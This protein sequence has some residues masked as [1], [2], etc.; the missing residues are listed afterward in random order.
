MAGSKIP[1]IFR[2]AKHNRFN[3]EPRYYDPIKEELEERESRIR[4]ELNMESRGRKGINSGGNSLRGAF[5]RNRRSTSGGVGMLRAVIL[6]AL[7]DITFYILT[8]DKRSLY[9]LLIIPVIY[10]GIRF[11]KSR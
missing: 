7:V 8:G 2:T 3:Y 4:T 10:A 1:S 9:L 5:Q 6:L 11:L